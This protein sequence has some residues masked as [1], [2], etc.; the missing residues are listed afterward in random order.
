VQAGEALLNDAGIPTFKYPDRAAQ[1][2]ELMWRYSENLRALYETPSLRRDSA[3]G[4][5]AHAAVAKIVSVAHQAGRVLLTEFESK[6]LLAFYGIP[7]VETHV[8]L[9]RDD[10]V[11]CAE[12][13]GYPAVLKVFSETLTHKSD[14]GGVRLNLCDASAVRHAW[15]EIHES[16]SAKAGQHHFLGV[17]V[18][19]MVK[20]E[21]YELIL[22]SSI[23]SQFGPVLL[24]GAGG[25]FVE[26]FKDRA[27]GLPPLNDTLAR[28][29]IEQTRIF[30]ALQGVR[31]R[32]P[33]DL[34][35]LSALLVRFSQLVA[36]QPWISEIDINPLLVSSE[37]TL[38]LD[39]RVIL[40]APGTEER[41]LPK[42]AIRAYPTR[43]V[44]RRKMKDGSEVTIRPI[45]PEDERLMIEFHR[46]LSERSVYLRYFAPLRL[47]LRIT[48][49]RLSRIC[50]IDYDREMALVA[51]RR[52][53]KSGQP[54]ILGVGRL[55]KLHGRDEAEF[56]LVISDGW[57]RHGLGTELLRMLV[58]VGRDER[59]NRISA[60]IL[61]DNHGMQDV[62][63]KVGFEMQRHPSASEVTAT[64]VL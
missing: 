30:V 27:L 26:V 60:P 47:D 41:A 37:R 5:T 28:R 63:R 31:G 33:V 64:L 51:E 32:K 43:Y 54:E 16:V 10:A 57:Q 56:A 29:L 44:Q 53:P 3:E 61:C 9:T 17:T 58:Q 13:V 24:F 39:A 52:Q 62:A 4:D 42:L 49:E 20:R 19:P 1:A 59:L 14:V 46:S 7:S 12:S 15:K 2:F 45:R 23:D 48:H 25:E 35:A 8:A 40:H 6:Q 18:Q 22:G 36:E 34:A 55:S 21:G 50:F 38:A 11:Q